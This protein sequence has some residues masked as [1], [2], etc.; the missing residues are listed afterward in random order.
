MHVQDRLDWRNAQDHSECS[1]QR[2]PLMVAPAQLANATDEI[3]R[4]LDPFSADYL[5]DPYPT[6]RD[7]REAAPV[8]YSPDLDHWIITRYSD[9]R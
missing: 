5:A 6:L 9:V 3:A 1:R 4:R 8:F 2:T 7:V